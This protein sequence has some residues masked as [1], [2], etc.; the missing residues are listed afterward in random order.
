MKKSNQEG[1][2]R[3]SRPYTFEHKPAEEGGLERAELHL[4][5]PIQNVT[6]S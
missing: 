5:P 2:K 4:P 6:C 1:E 3:K